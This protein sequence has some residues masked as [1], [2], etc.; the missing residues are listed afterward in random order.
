Y[1][2]L[3]FSRAQT[4]RGNATIESGLLT[5]VHPITS[6]A[7]ISPEWQGVNGG[8][9]YRTLDRTVHFL[10]GARPVNAGS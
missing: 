10:P 4:P 2:L 5:G 6:P 7:G 1:R 3:S 8:F 9:Y